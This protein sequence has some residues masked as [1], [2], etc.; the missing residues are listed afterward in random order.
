VGINTPK[1][2]NCEVMHQ[3]LSPRKNAFRY[4]VYYLGIPLSQIES[5]AIGETLNLNRFGLH[6][7]YEKDHGYRDGTSLKAW[8]YDMFDAYKF[9]K[10]KEVFLISMPR[11]L[12]YV[13]N[14]VS[15]W[16]CWNIKDELYA[17]VSEVNNTFGETHSYLTYLDDKDTNGDYVAK[18]V[19]H[20]SPFLERE[21]YY[22]FQF[23]LSD[24]SIKIHINLFDNNKEKILLTSLSGKF[25]DL[26]SMSLKRAFFRVPFATMKSIFLIHFQAVKLL[27]KKIKFISKPK[28]LDDRFTKNEKA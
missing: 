15:F 17:V 22:D 3:R 2:I 1:L 24:D 23:S 20:V 16:F 5:N 13:F 12:G 19:F 6:S 7:F 9:E 18:K 25:D 4:D 10:P 28:Q 21:G 26:N 14:P 8:L 11:I 27:L